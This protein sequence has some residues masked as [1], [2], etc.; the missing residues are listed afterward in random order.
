MKIKCRE[1]FFY[2]PV[3]PFARNG[4]IFTLTN[5]ETGEQVAKEPTQWL[6]FSQNLYRSGFYDDMSDEEVKKTEDMLKEMT[7]GVESLYY[8][9]DSE[10][11]NFGMSHEAA[12]LEMQ[13]SVNALHYFADTFLPE[14]MRD[15]FKALIGE[16]E[17]YNK[18][19]VSRHQNKDALYS[20]KHTTSEEAQAKKEY[21]T[22]FDKMKS[23]ESGVKDTFDALLNTLVNYTSGNSKN[24]AVQALLKNRNAENINRMASY[25]TQLLGV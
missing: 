18:E 15:S 23:K 1:V 24:D 12:R 3:S 4:N 19:S 22:L 11:H 5:I 16:Y 7:S 6:T 14:Q 9:T 17:N 20:V 25:W 10:R 2:C 13:S 21:Q 8:L